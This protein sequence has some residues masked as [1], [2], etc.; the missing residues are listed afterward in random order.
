MALLSVSRDALLS[1]PVRGLRFC[2]ASVSLLHILSFHRGDLI[3]F[4]ICLFGPKSFR[5]TIFSSNEI[6]VATHEHILF[7]ILV[8]LNVSENVLVLDFSLESGGRFVNDDRWVDQSFRSKRY[9]KSS[10]FRYLL[11]IQSKGE[12]F[13]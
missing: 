9:L 6:S 11:T 1:T 4:F 2:I 5:S 3:E 7:S 10:D 12:S 13:I 8:F